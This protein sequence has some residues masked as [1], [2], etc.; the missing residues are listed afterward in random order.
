MIIEEVDHGADGPGDGVGEVEEQQLVRHAHDERDVGDAQHAPHAQH[1]DHRH[2]GLA[3][4]AADRRHGVRIRQQEEERRNG[5]RLPRRHL[6]DLRRLR[7]QPCKLRHEDVQRQTDQLRDDDGAENAEP[8]PLLG[9]V[10]FARAEI[11]PRVGGQRHREA[12]DGQKREALQLG[13]CAAAGDG[14]LAERVDVCLHDDVRQTDDAVL[15][16]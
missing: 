3:R 16:T 10:I 9:T 5:P 14:E 7:K 6:D 8:S 4:A 11:L 13:V 15:D 1:D 12:R 2:D